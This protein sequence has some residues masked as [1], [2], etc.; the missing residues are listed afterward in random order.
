MYTV[1][2]FTE[3]GIGCRRDPLEANIWYVKAADAGED[4]ARLRLEV[5]RATAI[6]DSPTE[7]G[8]GASAKK[9]KKSKKMT[10]SNGGLDTGAGAG[11]GAGA[12]NALGTMGANERTG[13]QKTASRKD[14]TPMM[15]SLKVG[16]DKGSQ[17]SLEPGESPT[18][19]AK[20]RR[21]FFSRLGRS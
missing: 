3:R 16:S 12:E 13:S 17:V 9:K 11:A 14:S 5:I 21:S 18:E 6:G 2:Y 7:T 19:E 15:G 1:G 10:K 20:S 4:L 8:P